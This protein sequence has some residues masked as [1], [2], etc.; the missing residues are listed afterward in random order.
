MKSRT[1]KLLTFFYSVGLLALKVTRR[2][3][4]KSR[5]RVGRTWGWRWWWEC[6]R[7]W[8]ILLGYSWSSSSS[9][10]CNIGDHYCK[11]EVSNKPNP[12]LT[13]KMLW[14]FR[15]SDKGYLKDYLNRLCYKWLFICTVWVDLGL[16]KNL[17][18]KYFRCFVWFRLYNVEACIF[19]T[20]FGF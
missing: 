10:A 16:T 14:Q 1:G 19:S 8:P 13:A 7:S 6:C 2:R 5:C 17:F 3:G 9:E 20:F 18:K 12:F 4:C 15:Y 11:P